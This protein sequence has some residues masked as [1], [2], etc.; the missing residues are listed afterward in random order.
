M[1]GAR[2]GFILVA[3]N[4]LTTSCDF[5]DVI[6]PRSSRVSP[7]IDLEPYT[8][9]RVLFRGLGQKPGYHWAIF[10]MFRLRAQKLSVIMLGMYENF[11]QKWGSNPR[12]HLSIGT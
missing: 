3:F 4:N 8:A 10:V 5:F 2:K 6:T 12:G 1:A 11:Y 9:R 7:Q